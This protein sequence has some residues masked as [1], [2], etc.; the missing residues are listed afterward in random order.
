MQF[1]NYYLAVQM[2]LFL[3]QMKAEKNIRE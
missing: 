1:S 3:T 2:Q